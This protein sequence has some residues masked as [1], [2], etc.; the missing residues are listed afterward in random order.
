MLEENENFATLLKNIRT[1]EEVSLDQL[2]YGIMSTSQLARIE[3]GERSVAKVVR[4]RLLERLGVARDLYENLLDLEDYR[5]WERQ[6]DILHAVREKQTEQA[7]QLL[8]EYEESLEDDENIRR[9]FYLVMLADIQKKAEGQELFV[10]ECYREAL[11]LTVPEADTVWAKQRPL[12]ILEIN[13]LLENLAYENGMDSFLKYK[14]LLRY[15]EDGCYDEISK[16]KIYP[17]IAFYS[18]KKRMQYR[19]HL[20]AGE[21]TEC[22]EICGKTVERLR[23]AGRTYYLVEL[24]EIRKQLLKDQLECLPDTDREN[25]LAIRQEDETLLAVIRKLY[26]EYGVTEYME[27]CTYLYQ[28]KW[29]FPIGEVLKIRRTMFGMTQEQLCDGICSVKSLRR[30]EQGKTDIQREV[31][32][33]LLKRLGL[34]GQLQW[35]RLITSDREVVRLAERLAKYQNGQNYV[36]TRKLL[37]RLKAKVTM[38]IPQNKQFIIETE[39]LLDYYEKKISMRKFVDCETEILRQTLKENDFRKMGKIY[40]TEMEITCIRNRWRG[41][42][43]EEKKKGIQFLLNIYEE[44]SSKNG[45]ANAISMYEFVTEGAVSELGNMGE[46]ELAI[47]IDNKSIKESLKCRRLIHIDYKLYDIF[48]NTQEILKKKGIKMNLEKMA[49]ELMNCISISHYTKRFFYEKIYRDKLVNVH[50]QDYPEYHC[51]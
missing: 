7:E 42:K 37:E 50:C 9:Q 41:L 28:Q 38:E 22:L 31:R 48:W 47:L 27:D 12:S 1:E 46:H 11:A 25:H 44:Y 19:E 10:R 36:E 14:V 8:S 39:A 21:R 13:L 33:K 35:T 2:A 43:N 17:K 51:K 23:D 4:D 18:L 40:L 29:V 5:E 30:A 34:S 20:D 15:V 16:A 49:D 32:E 24:L 45:I 3:K 26:Q 6:K